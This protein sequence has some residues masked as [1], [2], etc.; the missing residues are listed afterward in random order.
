MNP[1]LKPEDD[2]GYFEATE[3][4]LSDKSSFSSG[5]PTMLGDADDVLMFTS[6]SSGEPF[7]G[8]YTPNG[9]RSRRRSNRPSPK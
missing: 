5:L 3:G 9:A 2:A 1:P 8:K 7:V 6:R 4:P